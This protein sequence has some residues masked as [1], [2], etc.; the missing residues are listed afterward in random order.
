MASMSDAN[1][2]PS[3]LSPIEHALDRARLWWPAASPWSSGVERRCRQPSPDTVLRRS[4][5]ADSL[6]AIPG[7]V[8]SP[9]TPAIAWPEAARPTIAAPVLY[10]SATA[11]RRG[12]SPSGRFRGSSGVAWSD[13]DASPTRRRRS[14]SVRNPPRAASALGATSGAG[15]VRVRR[16]G[17]LVGGDGEP[18][19][20]AGSDRARGSL[21]GSTLGSRP[22]RPGG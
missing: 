16:M 14:C 13:A 3:S 18:S 4:G 2:S 17:S 19:V 11:S 1:G 20:G 12:R 9:G 15:S 21:L 8:E 6:R 7:L 10:W 5:S 22:C